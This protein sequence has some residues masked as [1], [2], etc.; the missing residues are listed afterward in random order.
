MAGE[1]SK[2]RKVPIPTVKDN[3]SDKSMPG[4]GHQTTS[5][6]APKA[7]KHNVQC[8]NKIEQQKSTHSQNINTS[9]D[10]EKKHNLR[11]H[12]PIGSTK[13]LPIC[14]KCKKECNSKEELAKHV[15]ENHQR[16]ATHDCPVCYEHCKTRKMLVKHMQDVHKKEKGKR[17]KCDDCDECFESDGELDMHIFNMHLKVQD[18]YPI[19]KQSNKL[20]ETNKSLSAEDLDMDMQTEIEH[21]ESPPGVKTRSNKSGLSKMN[22]KRKSTVG[23]NDDHETDSAQSNISKPKKTRRVTSPKATRSKTKEASNR[24]TKV[25][26]DEHD[27]GCNIKVED[28]TQSE[29]TSKKPFSYACDT[30][31][32]MFLNRSMCEKHMQAHH[33]DMIDIPSPSKTPPH[34]LPKNL[35]EE[36]KPAKNQCSICN[37]QFKS[38]RQLKIH[39]DAHIE[40][41]EISDD[42]E[43]DNDVNE[44]FP[45]DKCDMEFQTSTD[46]QYHRTTEHAD[47]IY[48]RR[49]FKVEKPNELL[50]CK[51]CNLNFKDKQ[52]FVDHTNS[53]LPKGGKSRAGTYKPHGTFC[54]RCNKD[55][56]NETALSQHFTKVHNKGRCICAQCGKSYSAIG[57]LKT[58]MEVEHGDKRFECTFEGCTSQF[59]RKDQLAV[60]IMQHEG[61]YKFTCNVCQKGFYVQT[62]LKS[63]MN[64]HLDHRPH[65]CPKC[66]T[67]FFSSSDLLRHL[68]RCGITEKKF[69][70]KL[71]ECENN[72]KMFKSKEGLTL[73]EKRFHH[74]GDKLIC[75]VCGFETY[76][77]AVMAQHDSKHK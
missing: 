5:V 27:E 41:I 8:D 56:K 1:N 21:H 28:V 44:W 2:K 47:E 61:T 40:N 72:N 15:K 33:S 75:P 13:G 26:E 49:K 39:L 35:K 57:T 62:H 51:D 37:K 31:M 6:E 54:T 53:H 46:L 66:N 11:T 64:S 4:K 38:A 24:T 29:K 77:K 60:H 76:Y 14:I 10:K 3:T 55:F 22:N 19:A 43:T 18:E 16:K 59:K 12:A 73:H 68:D 58:H 17:T 20:K 69:S 63:H 71:G 52:T 65:K 42:K 50:H 45:C 48:R 34:L 70:C 67:G 74:L 7:T 36:K 32:I 25:K 23:F 9:V 30:C